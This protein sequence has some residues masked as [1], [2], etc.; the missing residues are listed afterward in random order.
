MERGSPSIKIGNKKGREKER[1]TRCIKWYEL[2]DVN[3]ALSKVLNCEEV[4]KFKK[5]K[6]GEKS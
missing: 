4:E 2:L 3:I 6:T 5:P 1:I